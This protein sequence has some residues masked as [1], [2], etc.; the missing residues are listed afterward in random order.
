MPNIQ[1]LSAFG[2]IINGW[3]AL[4]PKKI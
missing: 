1:A 2:G 4:T 3:Q